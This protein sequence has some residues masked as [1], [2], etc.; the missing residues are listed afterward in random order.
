MRWMGRDRNL[1]YPH[2]QL[3]RKHGFRVNGK[4][5]NL[6]GGCIHHDNGVTRNSRI[7]PC[8]GVPCKDPEGGRI[9]H[10]I[11]SSHYPMSRRL[12]KPATSWAC[13]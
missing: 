10:A 7:P 6:R 8:G 9:Q 12:L 1:W 13:M 5:V 3:D 2:L 4:V 11:R